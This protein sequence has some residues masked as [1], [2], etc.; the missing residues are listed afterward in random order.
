M[1]SNVLVFL[2]IYEV[3]GFFYMKRNSGESLVVF[4]GEN[5]DFVFIIT[6]GVEEGYYS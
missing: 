5:M 2:L 1:N 6:R 4:H 3:Y